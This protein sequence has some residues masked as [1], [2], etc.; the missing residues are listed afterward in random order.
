MILIYTGLVL[1]LAVAGFLIQR[2]VSNLERKFGR[3]ARAV[4]QVALEP[5]YKVGTRLDP[6]QIAKRQYQLGQ[7]VQKRDR[8]EQKYHAWQAFADRF[9]AATARVKAWKGKKLPY[10]FGVVDVSCLLYTIDTLG[11]GR[12]INLTHAWHWLK[13]VLGS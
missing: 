11:F 2:R 10:T 8:V 9:G 3:V 4:Q 1:I 12:H 5:A 6:C 7:L 13:T